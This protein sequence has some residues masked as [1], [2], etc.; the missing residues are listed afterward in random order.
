[1]V[2]HGAVADAGDE[3]R[4]IE[5]CLRDSILEAGLVEEGGKVVV[6]RQAERW[7]RGVQP[8]DSQLDCAAGV[9]ARGAWVGGCVALGLGRG[10]MDIGPLR[11]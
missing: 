1:M 5:D 6:V 11:A 3:Q 2:V 10:L 7:V 9:K 4:L 8:A